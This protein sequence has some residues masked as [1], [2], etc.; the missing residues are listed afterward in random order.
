MSVDR[1][2]FL[3]MYGLFSFVFDLLFG[4][5]SSVIGGSVPSGG[6]PGGNW[7]WPSLCGG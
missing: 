5:F 6:V 1:L 7:S 2:T 4:G 3:P